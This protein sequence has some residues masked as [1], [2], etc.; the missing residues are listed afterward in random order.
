[1]ELPVPKNWQDFENM[2]CDA[3]AQRWKST[4]LHKNGR[5]GQAQHGVDIY[6]PDDIGRPV[7]IQCKRYKP[8][9]TLQQVMAEIKKAE[10]FKGQLTTLFIATTGDYDAVLQ[11]QVRL[12]SDK[13]V[14][15][16]QFAVALLFWDDIV[17]GLLLNAAVFRAHYPQIVLTDPSVVDK[18]RLIAAL[19][20]GYYGADIW[21]YI[22]LIYGEFGWMAQ[23]DPDELIA[24]LRILERRAQQL[25]A[26][27]DATPILESLALVRRVCLSE[28]KTK[29]DWDP[30]EVHAKRIQ[31]RL[32]KASS[33]LPLAE[34]NVLGLGLQL[35]R[36]YH[37]S[38]DPPTATVREAVETKVRDVL[39]LSS[40]VAIGTKFI[41]AN[42]AHSGYQ[43][44]VDIYS[45]LNHEIRFG[46]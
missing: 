19:E 29:S 33:L 41:A 24:N 3:L 40:D 13:R 44:A 25:L 31:S 4:T 35:G 46:L 6:G 22:V 45:L 11:Q 14:A 10:T 2:V 8:P 9:L 15:N 21:A 12:L 32:Q 39:P 42:K 28:K 7:G 1:M 18:E 30:A 20:L 23:A 16:D 34:S 26:P 17:S 43:W 27:D 38:D 5:S 36:I 37:H